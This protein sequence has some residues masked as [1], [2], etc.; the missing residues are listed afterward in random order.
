MNQLIVFL[1]QEK[2]PPSCTKS[3]ARFSVAY[4]YYVVINSWLPRPTL[5]HNFLR[6]G[7]FFIPI[8]QTCN[9]VCCRKIGSKW[10][11]NI[12]HEHGFSDAGKTLNQ[13]QELKQGNSAKTNI[14]IIIGNKRF[15]NFYAIIFYKSHLL[16][17][18]NPA[19]ILPS[20]FSWLLKNSAW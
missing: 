6:S 9:A 8:L 3:C 12:Y 2:F 19:K 20:A 13:Q 16:L 14:A 5:L 11:S 7:M 18:L 4:W 1:F 17:S 10:C 15:C